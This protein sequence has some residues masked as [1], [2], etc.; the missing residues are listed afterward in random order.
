MGTGGELGLYRTGRGRGMGAQAA[1]PTDV[2]GVQCAMVRDGHARGVEL[3]R[4]VHVEGRAVG[5]GREG[6]G[7]RTPVALPLSV[8]APVHR[9]I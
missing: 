4:L 9:P 8:A 5:R 1:A 3:A 6:G 2:D 7:G